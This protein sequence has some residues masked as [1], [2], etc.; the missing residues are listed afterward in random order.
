MTD[1]QSYK[2]SDL[3][4]WRD[5]RI[6]LTA[7]EYATQ[8]RHTFDRSMPSDI[9]SGNAIPVMYNIGLVLPSRPYMGPIW[10]SEKPL[11]PAE[12]LSLRNKFREFWL[13][14]GGKKLF[15]ESGGTP[16]EIDSMLQHCNDGIGKCEGHSPYLSALSKITMEYICENYSLYANEEF[17]NTLYTANSVV[18]PISKYEFSSIVDKSK[19]AKFSSC[20][21]NI[22]GL[23]RTAETKTNPSK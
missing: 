15:P 11:K 21:T 20:L 7:I 14:Q 9:N 18:G 2:G 3:V 8:T 12:L 5:T 13:I 16:A 22:H 4:T 10:I 6:H 19:I 17:V 23:P 1:S